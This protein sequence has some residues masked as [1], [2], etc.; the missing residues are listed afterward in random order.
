MDDICNAVS[1]DTLCLAQKSWD[2]VSCHG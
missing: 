2:K 1:T